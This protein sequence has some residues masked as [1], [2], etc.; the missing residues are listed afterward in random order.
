MD[1]E[2]AVD[3]PPPR[4]QHGGA[5]VNL[6]RKQ[7]KLSYTRTIDKLVAE[8]YRQQL[9]L[10]ELR[11]LSDAQLELIAELRAQ[12]DQARAMVASLVEG[13]PDD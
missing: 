13:E 4:R 10:D 3:G 1:A 2:E 6:T 9:A 5:L 8:S 12:R 7:M 11:A